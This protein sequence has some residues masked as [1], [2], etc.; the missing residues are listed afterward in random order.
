MCFF[1]NLHILNFN[2]RKDK[3]LEFYLRDTNKIAANYSQLK[4]Y[5]VYVCYQLHRFNRNLLCEES[6]MALIQQ[7]MRSEKYIIKL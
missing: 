7:V 5:S 4:H 6:I 3:L 2:L 1:S